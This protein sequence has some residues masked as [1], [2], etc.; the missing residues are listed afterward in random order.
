[1]G[2]QMAQGPKRKDVLLNTLLLREE[3]DVWPAMAKRNKIPDQVTQPQGHP[4]LEPLIISGHCT[5]QACMSPSARADALP[6]HRGPWIEPHVRGHGLVHLP[7]A[8]LRVFSIEDISPAWQWPCNIL[9]K[10]AKVPVLHIG[11]IKTAS[12][13]PSAHS[14]LVLWQLQC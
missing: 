3:K 14:S 12:S 4:V 2:R 6:G 10:T 9:A 7:V 13:A 1:M 8:V 5:C 11:I